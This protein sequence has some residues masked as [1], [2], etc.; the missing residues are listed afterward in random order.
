MIRDKTWDGS[1]PAGAMLS[2]VNKR[3]Y[4]STVYFLP[5]V[6]LDSAQTIADYVRSF[7]DGPYGKLARELKG[8]GD[9]SVDWRHKE[10]YRPKVGL[11]TFEGPFQTVPITDTE[12]SEYLKAAPRKMRP[13]LSLVREALGANNGVDELALYG[14]VLLT[15]DFW[16]ALSALQGKLITNQSFVRTLY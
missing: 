12:F 2:G 6:D 9:T 7:S 16:R 3:Q 13:P 5:V 10:E 8:P 4:H 1:G 14:I 15:E 11:L